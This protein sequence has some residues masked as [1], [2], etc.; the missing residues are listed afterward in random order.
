MARYIGPV[1]RLCRRAGEKLYLKGDRCF[2]PKCA[3]QKRPTPPGAVSQRRRKVSDR[4]LQLREKQRARIFYGLLERQFRGYYDDALH[5]T[6]VTGD[7]LIRTLESR[8]DNVV[9]RLGLA[10]S[11]RQARQIVCHGHISVNQRKTDIPSAQLK[12]GDQVAFTARG[13]K[14]EYAKTVKEVLSAKEPPAWLSLDAAAMSG[15]V[16]AAPTLEHAQAFFDPN[17]IVE[18]YSR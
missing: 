4:G 5:K 11:R 14:S 13:V 7:N 18:Y 1:C 6:G 15:R 2:S 12:V 16:V 8:L 3:F 9:Y 17:V 10:D